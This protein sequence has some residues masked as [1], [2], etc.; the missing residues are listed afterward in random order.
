MIDAPHETATGAEN[1]AWDLSIFYQSPDDPAI[2]R[3]ITAIRQRASAYAA[4]YRGKIASLDAE[5]I[6]DALVEREAIADMAGRLGSYAGLTFVTETNNPQRGALYQKVQEIGAEI[7]QMLLF[8]ELE[9]KALSDEQTQAILTDPTLGKYAHLLEDELKMRPHT[10]SEIEEQIL[11]EKSVTGSG[12]WVRFFTQLMGALRYSWEGGELTDSQILSKLYSADREIRRRAAESVTQGL[13]TRL[14]ETTYVFNVLAAD[15]MQSDRRRKFPSWISDRNLSNKAP[16]AVVDALV[17]SVTS[18]YEIVARHYRLKR[19]LMG[20]DELYDYDRYAPLPIKATTEDYTWA[21]AREIVQSSYTAFSP[22]AGAVVARFFDENWIDAALRPNKR[23]GAFATATVPSAHP[24][25]LVNFTGKARDVSTLAH[26][27]GHGL[28][29]YLA[30]RKMGLVYQYTPLT[31]AE[32]ASVFGEMLTFQALLAKESDPAARLLMLSGKLEDSF[33]TVFRQISMNR[34][35]DA[36][37]TARRTEGE[38]SSDRLS[39]LWMQTQQAMFGDSVTLRSDYGTWWSYIPHFLGTPG[40]VYAYAFGELLVLALYNLYQERGQ[41]FVP[42]YLDLLAAG[43]SDYPDKL[44]AKVGIDLNDPN[45]WNGGLAVLSDLVN[46]E[47]ALAR[48]VFP[49]KFA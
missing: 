17:N 6:V 35:E 49:E 37:H 45:F 48:Q 27:L 5:G 44:L 19:V 21:E 38:L 29:Q 36:Y 2:E 16:D 40:Y 18:H 28:H 8:F 9:W 31:T 33:A 32:T 10:L 25:V 13:S 24:F 47:E 41:A 43:D 4:E 42:Q 23:G 14:M 39:E 15:K 30:Q 3:D 46:Q 1:V 34:F 20:V 22:E 11:V 26:E 7:Q 12:A